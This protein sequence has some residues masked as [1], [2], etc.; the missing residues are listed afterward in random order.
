MVQPEPPRV[1]NTMNKTLTRYMTTS[2]EV[3]EFLRKR[4]E[5][6]PEYD[7][8]LTVREVFNQFCGRSRQGQESADELRVHR[9]GWIG[10]IF[11]PQ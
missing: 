3:E 5:S 9:S 6:Y 2:D 8:D 4:F 11:M 7:F 10:G 1:E